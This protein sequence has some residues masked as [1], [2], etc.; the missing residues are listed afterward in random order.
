MKTITVPADIV[1]KDPRTDAELCTKTMREFAFDV[2]LNDNRAGTKPA[3]LFRWLKVCEKFENCKVGAVIELDDQD[4]DRLVAIVREP[5][6]SYPP[7]VAMQLLP[8]S[9]AVE[10]AT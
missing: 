5:Q 3:E 1:C 2:W 4:Y 7:I 6:A 9:D 10:K 8:F